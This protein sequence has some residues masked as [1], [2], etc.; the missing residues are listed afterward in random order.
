MSDLVADRRV[1]VLGRDAAARRTTGLH[2]LEGPAV[3]D[4]AADVEDDLPQG[5]AH[6]HLDQAGVDDAAG[7]REDLGALRLADADGGVLLRTI[8]QDGRDAGQRL[9]VVDERGAAPQ[10][11]H[12]RIRRARPGCTAAAFDRGD[13]GGL[14]A[15][16]EGAG[17]E[18]DLHVEGEGGV[19]DVVAEVAGTLR[20]PD[21]RAQALHRQRV[22]RAAVD[23]ALAGVDGEGRDGH[24]LEHPVGVALEDAAVHERAGVTLVGVADDVL[25]VAGGL[26]HGGP[27]EA[28]REAGAAATAQAALG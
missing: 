22:L 11:G 25:L 10:A 3:D 9:H 26:G 1:E 28:G 12:R 23:V 19:H 16:H 2:R 8:A 27:L 20:Q 14:L 17:T 21:G 5:H 6:G 4:A 13:E 7:E 15:A 24:A 18:A